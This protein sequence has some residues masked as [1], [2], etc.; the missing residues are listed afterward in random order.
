MSKPV[1]IWETTIKVWIVSLVALRQ[2][3]IFRTNV[4]A[5]FDMLCRHVSCLIRTIS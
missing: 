1:I 2:M 3:T 5:N 4:V